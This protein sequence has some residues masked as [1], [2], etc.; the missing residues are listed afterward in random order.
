MAQFAGDPTVIKTL[1]DALPMEAHANLQCRHDWR[2]LKFR[3]LKK[4]AKHYHQLGSNAH[5]WMKLV[6]DRILFL[7]GDDG[8]SIGAITEP[9]TVTAMMQGTLDALLAKLV[10]YE[11]NIQVAMAAKDDGTR[12]LFEH[13]IKWSQKD[14]AWF[15]TQ[16]NLIAAIG[17]PVYLSEKL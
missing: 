13:L 16:L 12:N 6:D 7:G 9:P 5:H 4:L 17:E 14:V 8:Y 1:Q 15:Q 3:G 11:D 10:A 2:S